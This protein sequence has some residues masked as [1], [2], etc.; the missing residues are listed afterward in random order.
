LIILLVTILATGT[1]LYYRPSY[2]LVGQ[3]NWWNVLTNG[4][5]MGTIQ[6]IL[7]KSFIEESFFYVMRYTAGGVIAGVILAMVTGKGSSKKSS[8]K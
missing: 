4:Y 8:K 3:L 1:G 6:G 7:T 5:F 2:P